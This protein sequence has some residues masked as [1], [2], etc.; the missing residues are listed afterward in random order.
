MNR[1]NCCSVFIEKKSKYNPK[2]EIQVRET[3]LKEKPAE[4]E[5]GRVRPWRLWHSVCHCQHL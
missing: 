2:I 5:V 1:S 3:Y 4:R